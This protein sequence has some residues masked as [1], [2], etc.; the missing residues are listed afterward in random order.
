[1][2]IKRLCHR[3][4]KDC[5]NLKKYKL[6]ALDNKISTKISGSKWDGLEVMN[7][8]FDVHKDDS[9]NSYS[10]CAFYME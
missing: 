6:K 2:V 4:W 8:I 3:L 1:V 10:A 9:G 7:G 5:L